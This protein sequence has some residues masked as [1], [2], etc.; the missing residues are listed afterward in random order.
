[1][2]FVANELPL[3]AVRV[4]GRRQTGAP[5]G[6]VNL[7]FARFFSAGSF[8]P[9][10]SATAAANVRDVALVLDVS[11]SMQSFSGRGTRLT[12]LQSAVNVFLDEVERTSPSTRIS[13]TS[14]S[15]APRKLLDL[16]DDFDRIRELVDGFE[17]RG[18]TAIGD[19]LTMGSDSLVKDRERREF[20]AKTVILMTDG[21]HNTGPSPAVTVQTA[22]ARNQQV[23]TVTFSSGAN[24]ALMEEVADATNGGIHL[25]ADDADDLAA[26]FREIARSL[27]VVLVE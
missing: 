27:S 3:T 24:Q 25:H 17:A 26:V 12:A 8:Q 19:A 11:G 14:Y 23:H 18:M 1:L 5:D 4:T 22:V 20:A 7:F 9:V 16:T 13:L 21:N 10:E 2:Q 6:R 15:T